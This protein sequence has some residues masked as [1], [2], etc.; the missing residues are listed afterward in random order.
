VKGSGDIADTPHQCRSRHVSTFR[1]SCFS[2]PVAPHYG[3]R[4]RRHLSIIPSALDPD[5]GRK[6]RS[7]R[8]RDAD[9]APPTIFHSRQP[10]LGRAIR[11]RST[12]RVHR[13]AI[14]QTIN[15]DVSFLFGGQNVLAYAAV[16]GLSRRQFHDAHR[17]PLFAIGAQMTQ[18]VLD[19][20]CITT[21]I[22]M[23]R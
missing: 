12:P 2:T 7:A 10:T 8:D 5:R 17:R 22:S 1:N 13:A 11:T 4:Q 23:K 19:R 14:L 20:A 18:P 21:S 16:I 9:A 6:I 15:F 3:D